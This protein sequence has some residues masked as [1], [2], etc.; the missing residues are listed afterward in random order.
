MVMTNKNV[1]PLAAAQQRLVQAMMAYQRKTR[2]SFANRM[3]GIAGAEHLT[4]RDWALLEYVAE[5]RLVGH[6][7]AVSYMRGKSNKA[8]MS[9]AAIAQAIARLCKKWG[10]LLGRRTKA[11]ERKKTLEL[12]RKGLR[13]IQQRKEVRRDMYLRIFRTWKPDV[14]DPEFCERMA[15]MFEHGTERADE[16][17]ATEI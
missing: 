5:R 8:G 11:D 17:F 16:V 6:A 15:T 7:D 9:E 14:D 1:Q 3:G 13:V 4:E 10:L 2:E 12:T